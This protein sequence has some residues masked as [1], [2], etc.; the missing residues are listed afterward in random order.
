MDIKEIQVVQAKM[1]AR[2]MSNDLN[3]HFQWY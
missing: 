2:H 3:K 1:I